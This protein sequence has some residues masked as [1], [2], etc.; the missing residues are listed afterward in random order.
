[1]LNNNN[2]NSLKKINWSPKQKESFVAWSNG[3]IIEIKCPNVDDWTICG[4]SAKF[5]VDCEYRIK[6]KFSYKDDTE[7]P[8]KRRGSFMFRWRDEL[9]SW[10][11]GNPVTFYDDKKKE[12][13]AL[14][15]ESHVWDLSTLYEI[16]DE[17]S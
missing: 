9:Q 5:S 2:N 12:W 16:K 4:E 1:M 15:P 3:Y 6:M 7:I 14:Q 11:N 8:F 17:T 13:H 10:L